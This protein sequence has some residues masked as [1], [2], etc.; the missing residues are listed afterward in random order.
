[1]MI[2]EH[3]AFGLFAIVMLGVSYLF[4]KSYSEAVQG[5]MEN[6]RYW[7]RQARLRRHA[8]DTQ[9]ILKNPHLYK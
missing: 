4:V 1:M 3:I 9:E 7:E 5:S 8:E 2:G 6:A